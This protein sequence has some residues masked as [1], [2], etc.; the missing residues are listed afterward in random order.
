MTEACVL[1]PN[2]DMRD[3]PF[4]FKYGEERTGTEGRRPGRET[5]YL[6]DDKYSDTD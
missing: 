2:E 4:M 1:F 3:L 6:T 5:D